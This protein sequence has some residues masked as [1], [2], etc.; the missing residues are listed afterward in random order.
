MKVASGK[1]QDGKIIL[2]ENPF[3]DGTEVTILA[4]EGRVQLDSEEE[5]LLL[6]AI[7]QAEAGEV[8]DGHKLLDDLGKAD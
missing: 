6:E 1:V 8:I 5:E 7:R 2:N 3:A 4:S